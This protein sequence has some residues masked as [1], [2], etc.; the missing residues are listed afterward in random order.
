MKRL[1]FFMLLVFAFGFIYAAGSQPE[2]FNGYDGQTGYYFNG[3]TGNSKT[4]AP[5]CRD[6]VTFNGLDG[7]M[8]DNGDGSGSISLTLS[9]IPQ[10]TRHFIL[11]RKINDGGWETILS[12]NLSANVATIGTSNLYVEYFS[13]AVAGDSISYKIVYYSS[14]NAKKLRGI[15]NTLEFVYQ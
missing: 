10:G 12:C 6:L 1:V 13:G 7:T 4:N 9:S 5:T 11:L 14:H 3:N 8:T 15:S 2:D